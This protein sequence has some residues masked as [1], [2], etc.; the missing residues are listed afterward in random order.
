MQSEVYN[1]QAESKCI[2]FILKI[3]TFLYL[4]VTRELV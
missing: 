2:Y 4:R 3:Q 1:K